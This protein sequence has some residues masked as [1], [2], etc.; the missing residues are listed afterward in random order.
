MTD[1]T[2]YTNEEILKHYRKVKDQIKAL[3]EQEAELKQAVL[4]RYSDNIV[5]YAD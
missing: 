3:E 1:F 5:V 4:S 2:K